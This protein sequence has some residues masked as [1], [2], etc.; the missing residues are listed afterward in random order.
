M[1]DPP[2]WIWSPVFVSGKLLYLYPVYSCICI[3]LSAVSVCS[4][5]RSAPH[6]SMAP[7]RPLAP[8]GQT[9]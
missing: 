8:A 2:T 3:L 7:A 5:G 1:V 6:D 9:R 4:S